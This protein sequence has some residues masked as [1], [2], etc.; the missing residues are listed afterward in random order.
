M[1]T[2]SLLHARGGSGALLWLALACAPLAGCAHLPLFQHGSGAPRAARASGGVAPSPAVAHAAPDP[3]ARAARHL[4]ADSLALAEPELRTLLARNGDDAAALSMLSKLLYRAGRHPEAIALLQPVKQRPAAFA[5][6]ARAALLE[7]LALH[8][9]ALGHTPQARDA[10]AEAHAA[11]GPEW[12]SAAVYVTLRGD[13]PDSASALAREVLRRDGKSA[14]SLNNF[15]ITRLRAGDLEA[16]RR[17]F[18]DAMARDPSLP[19][20]YYNLAILEKFYRF[21]E[22]AAAR[23]FAA[24]WELSHDDPDSLRAAFPAS[25]ASVPVPSGGRP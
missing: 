1:T 4:A 6:D 19:G 12:S 24:Y 17:A 9:D 2:R 23:R 10:M 7:G 14:I 21:D 3:Y 22:G 15:G 5:P 18:D 11:G 20:P 16:A 25:L 8:E 13:A